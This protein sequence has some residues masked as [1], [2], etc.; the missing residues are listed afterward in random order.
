VA[1]Q[2]ASSVVVL[3]ALQYLLLAVSYVALL[4][5]DDAPLDPRRRALWLAALVVGLPVLNAASLSIQNGIALLFPAWVRLG[6]SRPNGVEAMGQNLLTMLSATLLLGLLLLVPAL[7]G[8]LVLHSLRSAAGAA[9]WPLALI[10]LLVTLGAEVFGIVSWL[11][12]IF[13]RTEPT[14]TGV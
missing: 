7:A 8:W 12:R 14:E 10:V 11:G 2:V 6:P 5:T 4:F 3:T 13:D 1:A 9:A